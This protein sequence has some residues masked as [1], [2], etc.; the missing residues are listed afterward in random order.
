MRSRPLGNDTITILVPTVVID[1]R[2]NTEYLEY[3]DGA[4]V[5]NCS[6]QPFLMT[7]KFQE[8]YTTERES[9]RTFFRIFVPVN[10]DTLAINE[11]YQ[12]R[13][14]GDIYEVHALPGEWRALNGRK[15]HIAFL[16]KRRI[17]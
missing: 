7:E 10:D 11:T 3:S 12:I 4:T 8:E 9:T 15:D 13:F 14:D 2:D 5:R 6:L 1:E 17:G 16:V